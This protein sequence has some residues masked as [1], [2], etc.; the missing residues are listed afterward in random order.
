MRRVEL[1]MASV[2]TALTELTELDMNNYRSFFK[3]R[4]HQPRVCES[5]LTSIFM[6]RP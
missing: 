1:E 3:Q 6:A 2:H 4:S 5:K